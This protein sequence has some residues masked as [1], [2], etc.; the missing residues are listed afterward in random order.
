M[1]DEFRYHLLRPSQIKARREA[2]PVAYVPIGTL[3]W[4]GHHLPI[5]AD[6]LQSE[7]M[8]NLC[9]QR[10]AGLL[11]LPCTTANPD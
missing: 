7:H 8:A 9:A 3:E 2:C 6:T 5:G 4:H 10:G 11:F 1:D